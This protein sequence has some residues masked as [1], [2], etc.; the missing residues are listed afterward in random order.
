M[1]TSNIIKFASENYIWV[2]LNM[3]FRLP[4]NPTKHRWRILGIFAV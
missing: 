4:A 2:A 3:H 1:I